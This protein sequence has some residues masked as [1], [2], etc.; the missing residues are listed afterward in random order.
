MIT[1]VLEIIDLER[2]KEFPDYL[3]Y[4]VNLVY[5]KK[6]FTF[7]VNTW[8]KFTI[9]LQVELEIALLDVSW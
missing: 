3:H 8:H 1:A 9:Q 7:I 2:N 5:K 4:S 6:K